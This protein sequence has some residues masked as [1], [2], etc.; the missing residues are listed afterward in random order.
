[1][2]LEPLRLPDGITSKTLRVRDLNMHTLQVGRHSSPLVLLLH[3]FPEL[4]F[5]WRHIMLPLANSGYF[6][7][8]PDHRGTGRTQSITPLSR[9]IQFEDDIAPYGLLNWTQ[10][11]VA[12][13]YALG[14][15]TAAA[16]VGHDFGSSVAG[17]CALVR[18]DIFKSVVCMSAPYGGPPE[19]PFKVEDTALSPPS[20]TLPPAVSLNQYLN[21]LSPPLKHYVVYNT[22]LTTNHDMLDAPQG[23]HTF[24]RAYFHVK[25]ADWDG[26]DP[27]PLTHISELSNLPQYYILPLTSSWPDVV[28]LHAPSED[29]IRRNTWLPEHDLEVYVCEFRRTG[30]QGGLNWYRANFTDA[31]L[32]DQ[33]RIFAGKKVEVPAAFISGVK[34]WGVYQIPG[35]VEKMRSIFT[36][37]ADEDFVLVKDAGHWVQQEQPKAVVEQLLG[38][39]QRSSEQQ[40]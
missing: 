26:N 2:A 14:Y 6:V 29:E 39:L 28:M 13:V 7:V 15:T 35:S 30:F 4:A 18:P 5:S 23:L 19:L 20:R 17:Y 11:V 3:G 27:H 21:S 34:D 38:F 16:V 1:M 33:L 10:D 22:Q 24:L 31:S 36:Q 12:L 9:Q 37:M 32:I 25:S 8:A 40:V